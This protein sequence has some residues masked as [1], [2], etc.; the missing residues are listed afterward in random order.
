MPLPSAMPT[1]I[2]P[3]RWLLLVLGYPV[4]AMAGVITHRDVFSLAAC[5]LLLSFLMAPALASRRAGPWATWLLTLGAMTWLWAQGLVSYL[6]ECVPIA[7]NVLLAS[8]FGRSLRHGATPLVARFIEALEGREQ[9]TLPGVASYARHL[10][11][12][13]ATLTALQALVLAVLLLCAVPGGV[14]DSLGIVS[15][16]SVPADVAQSYAHVGGYVLIAAAF[17]LEHVFRRWH[18]RHVHHLRLHELALGIAARW[19]Q[20]L[21]GEDFTS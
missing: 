11:V 10:T 21:R 9:L 17:L 18:L 19:P 6:L 3:R 16:W 7:V 20:L 8:L 1:K 4:L 15:P 5:V 2:T 14:L 12:F 13:W